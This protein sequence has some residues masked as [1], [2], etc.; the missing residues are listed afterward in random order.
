MA[1]PRRAKAPSFQVY[2]GDWR[3]DTAL[4]TCPL[5][6]RGLWWE[7]CCVMHDGDPYGHLAIRGRP[8]TDDRAAAMIGIP[9]A[10]YRRLLVELEEAGVPSRTEDGVLYS[11]RMVR[12]E[13]IRTVRAAAGSKGGSTRVNN[14]RYK[15]S[16]KTGSNDPSTSLGDASIADADEDAEA[17][18]MAGKEKAAT[19]SLAYHV[20]CVLALNAG[21]RANPALPSFREVSASEQRGAVTWEADGIPIE[22]VTG[23]VEARAAEYSPRP[24]NQQPHSLR[25]FDAAVRREWDLSQQPDPPAAA[26]PRAGRRRPALAGPFT[27]LPEIE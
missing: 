24:G 19:D 7:L 3:R 10:Q 5:E 2:P 23:V 18:A 12:D 26:L 20:R 8:I 21:L 25:Y 15:S 16:S 11:R 1:T 9:V 17:D 13:H 14:E 6:A 4:Q 22:L 27:P